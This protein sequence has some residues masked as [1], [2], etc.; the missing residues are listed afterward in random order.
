MLN[1]T[2]AITTMLSTMGVV[3]ALIYRCATVTRCGQRLPGRAYRGTRN[4]RAAF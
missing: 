2:D 4:L 1:A 3:I